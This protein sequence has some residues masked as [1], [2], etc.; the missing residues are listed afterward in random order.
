MLGLNVIYGG[1]SNKRRFF[2]PRTRYVLSHL[3]VSIYVCMFVNRIMQKLQVG[4]AQNL[5]RDGFHLRSYEKFKVIW[6]GK[7]RQ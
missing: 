1:V 7:K 6:I 4:I 3:L 2:T 5:T